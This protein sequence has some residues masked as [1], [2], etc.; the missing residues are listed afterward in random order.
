M[1]SKRSQKGE[2]K[3]GIG[4]GLTAP[5]LLDLSWFVTSV[6]LGDTWKFEPLVGGRILRCE[7]KVCCPVYCSKSAFVRAVALH[8]LLGLTILSWHSLLAFASL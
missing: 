2:E 6:G 8:S 3:H 4:K 1:A 5:A 7:L